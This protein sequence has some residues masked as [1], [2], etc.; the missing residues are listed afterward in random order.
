MT[1]CKRKSKIIFFACSII[2]YR[3]ISKNLPKQN[4]LELINKFSKGAQCKKTIQQPL[5]FL[6]TSNEKSERKIKNTSDL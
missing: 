1:N 5:I 3:K 6:Y 2:L 4:L